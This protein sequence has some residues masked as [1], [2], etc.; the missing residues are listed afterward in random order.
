MGQILSV[1]SKVLYDN[2]RKSVAYFKY[3]VRLLRDSHPFGGPQSVRFE[4][5]AEAPKSRCRPRNR[6]VC[7]CRPATRR[8]PLAVAG[9]SGHGIGVAE[10]DRVATFEDIRANPRKGS[11]PEPP[12]GRKLKNF[13]QTLS[14]RTLNFEPPWTALNNFEPARSAAPALGG[15]RR[16]TASLC[17]AD[18]GTGVLRNSPTDSVSPTRIYNRPKHSPSFPAIRNPPDAGTHSKRR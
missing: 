3:G 9:R 6:S 14:A 5:L 13:E 2:G 11:T 8:V 16:R 17:T 10:P 1:S 12:A 18:R 4:G 15:L 7:A